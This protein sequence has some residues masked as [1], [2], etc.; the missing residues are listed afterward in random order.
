MHECGYDLWS[1]HKNI[2]WIKLYEIASDIGTPLIIDTTTQNYT[3][4]HYVRVLVDLDLSHRIFHEIMVERE[5]FS[6]K[7]E[8]AYEWLLDDLRLLCSIKRYDQNC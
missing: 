8:F 6:F 1:C 5:G 3:F 4:G 7:M 2:G